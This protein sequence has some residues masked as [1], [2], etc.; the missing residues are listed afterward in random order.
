MKTAIY[1]GPEDI[2]CGEKAEPSISEPHQILVEV[3]ATSICGSDLHLYRGAMDPIMER[4]H[5]QIGHELIGRVSE[6]GKGVGKFKVGDRVSMAYSCS[7]GEC[8]MCEVGQTAHCETTQKAVYG[9]GI[10]FGDLNGTHTEALI[11][12]HAEGHVIKVPDAIDDASALSLSCSLPSAI[13]AN[14]LANIQPGENVAIIGCGPTGLLAMDIALGKSAGQV[15][16]IDQLDYRLAVAAKKGATTF[17]S[18][19][20]GWKEEAL[21]L[22]AGRGFDKIIEVVGYP[23][24]LQMCLDLIRP[25]GTIAAIG[26]FCDQEFNLVLADVFLRDISL[27]MNGFANVQ[28]Y[29]WEGIRLMERGVIN[30]A[31]YFSHEFSLDNIDKAFKTF[32]DKSDNVLK[33]LIRP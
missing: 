27:H 25:G 28:P 2:R 15:V 13:I 11:L 9:F 1:Y 18:T 26:V 17:N 14:S 33:T 4:G 12:P 10:P 24:T 16:C 31:E 20:E 6:V 8:Y 23:E 32:Y 21:A 30:P 19:K 5:S 22:T 3:S 29:M 7:C